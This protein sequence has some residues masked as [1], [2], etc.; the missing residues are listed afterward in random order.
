MACGVLE[1]SN[2]HVFCAQCALDLLA[3]K[4]DMPRMK[5]NSSMYESLAIAAYTCCVCGVAGPLRQSPVLD[6]A[7]AALRS[8]SCGVSA[9]GTVCTWTGLRGQLDAHQDAFLDE[10][11]GEPGI[12]DTLAAGESAAQNLL[13]DVNERAE[14]QSVEVGEMIGRQHAGE[15]EGEVVRFQS[16]VGMSNLTH[17]I[18]EVAAA[19]GTEDE[20]IVLR[21]FCQQARQL[22]IPPANFATVVAALDSAG[23]LP[24]ALTTAET[25]RMTI[26]SIANS[27]LKP[28]TLFSRN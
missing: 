9:Q 8:V 6:A 7:V 20:A 12:P 3:Q 28:L 22:D 2:G 16:A 1:C 5:W 27:V 4:S 23:V 11:S 21:T 18:H 13:P 14:L 10:H 19:I 15:E 26:R 24:R 25:A 17:T